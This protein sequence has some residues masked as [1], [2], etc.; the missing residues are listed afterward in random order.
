M[1]EFNNQNPEI[2]DD[3][4]SLD[5]K[6]SLQ[7]E[8]EVEAQPEQSAPTAEDMVEQLTAQRDEYLRSLQQTAA[9]FDNYRKRVTR[10]SLE[11]GDQKV[12]ALIVRLLP[13]LDNIEL[14]LAHSGEN[15]ELTSSLA[16]ISNSLFDILAKEGLEQI[17]IADVDFDPTCHEAVIH[18]P[19]E[20][21]AKVT[22]VLRTGYRW[23]QKVVRPAMV[24]VVGQG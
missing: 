17:N 21:R 18:E 11:V 9:D 10:Q 5:A 12:E 4:S 22:E 16:Q 20:G 8:D 7:P 3:L 1:S 15:P 2:P 13:A 19:G 6:E 14:A 23:K 24:K